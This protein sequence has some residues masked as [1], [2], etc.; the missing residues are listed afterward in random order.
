VMLGGL[1]SR[2]GAEWF[3]T[4]CCRGTL[5]GLAARAGSGSSSEEA[6]V[7]ADA[8]MALLHKAAATGYRDLDA[9]RTDEALSPL[10][11]REDFQSLMMD[12]AFPAKPFAR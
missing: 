6:A 5:A 11:G 8:V 10:R 2:S 1:A 12:L 9:Y 7:E 4:A 3:E